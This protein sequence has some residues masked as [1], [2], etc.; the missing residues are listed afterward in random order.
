MPYNYIISGKL[1][2]ETANKELGTM[3]LLSLLLKKIRVASFE[4]NFISCKT[5]G[6]LSS[7]IPACLNVQSFI[8]CVAQGSAFF[9]P[10]FLLSM[11]KT[12]RNK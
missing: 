3:F 6:C 2:G 7:S 11:V 9:S 4:T 5:K 8:C 10:P 12:P 1:I